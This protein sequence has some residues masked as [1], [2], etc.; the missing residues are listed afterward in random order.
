MKTATTWIRTE[1]GWEGLYG[2][3]VPANKQRDEANRIGHNWPAGVLEIFFQ[4]DGGKPRRWSRQK[5]EAVAKRT[6]LAHKFAEEH[7][8]KA[9]EQEAQRQHGQESKSEEPK[10]DDKKSKKDKKPE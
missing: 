10:P 5:A 1:K 7:A 3:D 9:Q 2:P 6:T 8:N 4:M